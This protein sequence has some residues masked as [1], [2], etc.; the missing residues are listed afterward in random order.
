MKNLKTF[1]SF[2][3]DDNTDENILKLAEKKAVEAEDSEEGE[4]KEGEEKVD[5]GMLTKFF[6]GHEDSGAKLA[7]QS[8][9]ITYLNDAEKALKANPDDYA[10]AKDWE[11][12]KIFLLGSADSNNY[13]GGLRVQRGG[14]KDK[15]F[16]IVYDAKA[17]G[18]EE[19]AASAGA[20]ARAW[21]GTK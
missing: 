19:L 16:F 20:G 8:K 17:S 11:K 5:E 4:E 13:R 10:Q 7:A 9:F 12:A 18:F 2:Q 6:T 14:G 21:S 15:R 1:E 3:A